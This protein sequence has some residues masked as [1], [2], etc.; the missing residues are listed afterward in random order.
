[1]RCVDAHMRRHKTTKASPGVAGARL[2]LLRAPRH[3]FEEVAI[4]RATCARVRPGVHRRRGRRPV[5]LRAQWRMPMG[6]VNLT[7]WME[8]AGPGVRRKTS[9][10]S[11]STGCRGRRLPLPLI[12]ANAAPD[13][14]RLDPCPRTLGHLVLH[15]TNPTENMDRSHRLLPPSFLMPEKA[16]FGPSV[17]AR[18][19]QVARTET[20][21]GVRQASWSGHIAWAWYRPRLAPS[22][23][24]MN[25]R[26]W[27]TKEPGASSPSC[28][29]T[30]PTAHIGMTP[31]AADHRPASR[32]HR[33]IRQSCGQS[34]PPP[35]AAAASMRFDFRLTL[36]CH[37]DGARCGR[38]IARPEQGTIRRMPLLYRG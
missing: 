29:K 27:K 20:E 23:K 35:K 13:R 9:P 12:N 21:W 3:S 6:P 8:A 38:A 19:R 7:R 34:I 25:A 31:E 14:K 22:P 4:T 16:R 24:A 18:S 32:R 11:A 5:S 28:E 10:P 30:E 17:S 36:G 26:G 1:M 33:R 2:N 37:A 15:S